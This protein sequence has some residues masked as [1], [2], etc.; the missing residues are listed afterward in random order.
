MTWL[1]LLPRIVKYFFYHGTEVNDESSPIPAC[2]GQK[3][4]SKCGPVSS[5]SRKAGQ[6]YQWNEELERPK[7]EEDEEEE[8]DS[9]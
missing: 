7:E 1:H 9:R 3:S 6:S 5:C 2:S 8:E 4:K